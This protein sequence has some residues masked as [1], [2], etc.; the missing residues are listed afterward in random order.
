[1][2]D[3][4]LKDSDDEDEDEWFYDSIKRYKQLRMFDFENVIHQIELTDWKTICV[5]GKHKSGKY[6]ILEL[7]LPEK[8]TVAASHEG[9]VKNC[10]LKM[11]S[12]GFTSAPV[13]Q[14]RALWNQR[15]ILVSERDEA[16]V[17]V[18]NL[19]VND[20]DLVTKAA[21]LTCEL[22]APRIAL[23]NQDLVLLAA[24]NCKDIIAI[25]LNAN[26]NVYKVSEPE[27]LKGFEPC[28]MS[29]SLAAICE[30]N[31]GTIVLHDI[32]AAK[33]CGSFLP[34]KR[35]KEDKTT[36][37][38][39]TTRS[40]YERNSA[41]GNVGNSDSKL[42]LVSTFGNILI[43]DL[44]NLSEPIC[45]V[46]IGKIINP[47]P[48][49][50]EFDLQLPLL[51]FSPDN[52]GEVSLSG[53]DENVY[54]YN[55]SS[56]DKFKTIFVHDGHKR[57]SNSATSCHVTSHAWYRENIMISASENS[58]LHCWQFIPNSSS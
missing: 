25:D 28:F 55:T 20:T 19:G 9:L 11:R 48:Q 2:Y 3:M 30:R 38:L 31:N 7:S 36:G 45:D 33:M 16:G 4:F 15:K 53:F 43:C 57:Q 34:G 49:G 51:N 14:V 41:Y 46:D 39:W 26:K 6:E 32:R 24:R 50:Q 10:D 5:A 23:N 21:S 56:S 35:N 54:I 47:H 37:A 18:Y 22:I 17:S 52:S 1:M 13:A 8:L 44:R 40:S 29:E 27:V 42:G 58:S 12:G